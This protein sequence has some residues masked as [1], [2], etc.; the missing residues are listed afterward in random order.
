[1]QCCPTFAQ[2]IV[3]ADLKAGWHNIAGTDQTVSDFLVAY[4][5]VSQVFSFENNGW[6]QDLSSASTQGYPILTGTLEP[7]R[8]YW[9]NIP[10][11]QAKPIITGSKDTIAI[12]FTLASFDGSAFDLVFSSS[13]D[14]GQSYST[15]SNIRGNI[16]SISAGQ[17]TLLWDSHLDNL[18][19][20]SNQ[21]VKL[22][23]TNN[24]SDFSIE[25]S[26]FN[27]EG[28][29][30]VTPSLSQ[31]SIVTHTQLSFSS[32]SSFFAFE[33][34]NL[35]F[36]IPENAISFSI[37]AFHKQNKDI[38]ISS[39]L[40]PSPQGTL[41]QAQI[42]NYQNENEYWNLN[43]I[44][45]IKPGFNA[46]HFPKETLENITAI[47]GLWSY[48][49]GLRE[50]STDIE[51][52]IAIRTS[53][54]SHL[55]ELHIQPYYCGNGTTYSLSQVNQAAQTIKSI[56]EG[57]GQQLKVVLEDT[58]IISSI[59]YVADDFNN[60]QTSLLMKTGATD[61]VN[62]FFIEDWDYPQS[63]SEASGTLGIAASIPGSFGVNSSWNGVI[64]NLA[65]HG[66]PT[67]SNI[68]FL[69]KTATHEIGHW[70]GLYHT[71]ENGGTLFDPL[72]D[73]PQCPTFYNNPAQCSDGSNLMFWL[74]DP[75]QNIVTQD[76]YQM[77][78][79]SPI[80][81]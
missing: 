7:S 65:L 24:N 17:N 50:Q 70:L 54:E 47:P 52:Q 5:Q 69:G 79:A 51:V 46:L 3:L 75:S 76:Q 45:E 14:N 34:Q 12:S 36:T 4:P 56:Y 81:R 35:Q 27:F 66:A 21:K 43:V 72:S 37:N 26:S 73:T 31:L 22:V 60:T 59:N 41:Q 40:S 57:N 8:G 74:A 30:P 71:T 2:A 44:P 49:I 19:S 9:I 13:S 18:Q 1:M 61:I 28:I 20:S 39:L 32:S 62:V 48:K 10:L 68:E 67:S 55:N 38:A 80:V 53:Q 58:K 25:S 15:S 78:K 64:V 29:T 63:T 33:S 6:R 77:L 23:L 42:L 11:I 16:T